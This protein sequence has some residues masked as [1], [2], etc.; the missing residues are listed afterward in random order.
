VT[1]LTNYQNWQIAE[2]RKHYSGQLDVLYAGK[3]LRL[4]HVTDALTNDLRGDGWSEETSALYSAA[5]YERHVAGLS[6][7]EKMALYLTGIDEPPADKV[8]DASPYPG[9]W[10]A[11]RWFAHLAAARGLRAWAENSG[12]DDAAKLELSARRMHADG[13]LGLMWAFESELYADPNPNGYAT[14]GEYEKVMALYSALQRIWLPFV[15]RGGM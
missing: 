1:A 10:S 14:I 12:Q 4:N 15:D 6:T 3:G 2:I 11:A 9:D 13:F 5:L 7:T 8:D